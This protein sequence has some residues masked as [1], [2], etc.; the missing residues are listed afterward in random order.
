[1]PKLTD[2]ILGALVIA[3]FAALF[4]Y[5]LLGWAEESQDNAHH[6]PHA[7]VKDLCEQENYETDA[8]I[9]WAELNGVTL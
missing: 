4:A 2:L 1:M 6:A 9:E 8:C 5:A 7:L 3:T